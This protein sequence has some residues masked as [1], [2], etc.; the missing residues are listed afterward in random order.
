MILPLQQFLHSFTSGS[1]IYSYLLGASAVDFISHVRNYY[2]IPIEDSQPQDGDHVGAH[3]GIASNVDRPLLEK[4]WKWLL[5]NPGIR[6][7]SHA[8]QKQLTLSEVEAHNATIEQSEQSIP[9]SEEQDLPKAVAPVHVSD[10]PIIVQDNEIAETDQSAKPASARTEDAAV[11]QARKFNPG[12]RLYASTIR[13]WH[14]LTGHAPDSNKVKSLDFICLS[15]IA[16][17]GPKGILQHDL[18]R[19]SG[20]D[21]RSLP[22]RTDRLHDCGYVEKKNVS[23]YL[24]NPKRLVHTSK[25][26]LKRFVN[27]SPDS[28]EQ[29]SD[30]GSTLPE[31]TKRPKK[32]AQ[33]ERISQVSG[34]SSSIV[35]QESV[36]ENT[37]LSEDQTIPL[38]KAD[39]PINN[40]I[41]D[42]VDRAGTKGMS[43][44][45][46]LG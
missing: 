3:S 30:P 26:T 40:Q 45:V 32:K 46:C 15:I 19:I 38:W 42:L 22:A 33:N 5:Q 35:A 21:K 16:A 34:R 37:V 44:T 2:I 17:S 8:A 13:M 31:T 41:F 14:A 7:G 9:I 4:V 25:C 18:V 10:V 29:T 39:R 20:Q 24:F 1:F 6:L 36:S 27:G 11:P 28:K 23:V 43:M 12:I